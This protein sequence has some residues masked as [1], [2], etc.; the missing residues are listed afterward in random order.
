MGAHHSHA[1]ESSQA[2]HA[3]KQAHDDST[4]FDS[5][6]CPSEQVRSNGLKVLEHKHVERL[7]QDLV[8]ILVVPATMETR[9]A[10]MT[11]RRNERIFAVY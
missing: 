8:R 3:L 11:N 5:F 7:T 4:T 9:S 1:V 6:D 10:Y 2:L